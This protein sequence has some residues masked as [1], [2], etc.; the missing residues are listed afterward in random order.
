MKKMKKLVA[1]LML[2]V[3]TVFV[4]TGCEKTASQVEEEAMKA[5]RDQNLATVETIASQSIAPIFTQYSYD[6]FAAVKEQ[7]GVV[8][9]P[10]FDNDIGSRWKAFADAHGMAVTAEVDE[11][12]RHAYEYTARIILTGEDGVQQALTITFDQSGNPYKSTLQA[13]SDDSKE[14]LGSKMA[15]AGGNTVTGLLVVFS[16]LVLLCLIIFCFKFISRE[17][18]PPTKSAPAAPKAPVASAA[19][20]Q[21]AE[22]D[23]ENDPALI[24]VIAAAIAAYEDKP[25]EGFVVRKVKR[26]RTNRW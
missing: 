22:T 18:V 8:F 7:G 5:I 11:V 24:A 20:A 14:T 17:P 23:L 2:A 12:M 16:V 4:A 15:T 3:L 25:M 21:A 10:L 9:G 6:Q 13:Y 1:V 19:P 26:L